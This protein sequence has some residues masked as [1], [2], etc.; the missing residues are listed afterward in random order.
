LVKFYAIFRDHREKIGRHKKLPISS[1][2][3]FIGRI[4]FQINIHP[5]RVLKATLNL[6]LSLQALFAEKQPDRA[7]GRRPSEL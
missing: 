2:Y 5:L 6:D 1:N 3:L 4:F 7:D